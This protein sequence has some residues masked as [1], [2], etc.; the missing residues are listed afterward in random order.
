MP[1]IAF[2]EVGVKKDD[3]IMGFIQ[4]NCEEFSN[5]NNLVSRILDKI[6]IAGWKSSWKNQ[7]IMEIPGYR[8]AE[9]EH[10]NK[11]MA[12]YF[13]I[14]VKNLNPYQHAKNCSVFLEKFEFTRTGET[15]TIPSHELR[16]TAFEW[17]SVTILPGSQRDFDAFFVKLSSPSRLGLNTHWKSRVISRLIPYFEKI[18]ALGEGNAT[19]VVVSENFDAIRATFRIKLSDNIES[20]EFELLKKSEPPVQKALKEPLW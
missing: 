16:W 12:R 6:E 20:I 2:Q 14:C 7:L 18:N 9:A 4:A 15:L 1:L 17:P 11:E 10:Y 5:R 13:Y 19:Y 3:G 8:Y